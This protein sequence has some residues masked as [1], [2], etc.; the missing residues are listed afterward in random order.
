MGG[1]KGM[2]AAVKVAVMAVSRLI[3]P[4]YLGSSQTENRVQ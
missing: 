1:S 3:W 4:T 2:G